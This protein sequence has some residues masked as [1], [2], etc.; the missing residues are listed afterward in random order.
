MRLRRWLRGV[1]WRANSTWLYLLCA[2]G[3][4]KLQGAREYQ[5]TIDV[6]SAIRNSGYFPGF[7]LRTPLATAA[8]KRCTAS[9]VGLPHL[10][11]FHAR[12]LD[13]EPL[14]RVAN[15]RMLVNRDGRLAINAP[16]ERWPNGAWHAGQVSKGPSEQLP[17]FPDL[18]ARDHFQ[19][20]GQ[21]RS[22]KPEFEALDQT[23]GD[24]QDLICKVPNGRSY[25]CT[26]S[27]HHG[28]MLNSAGVPSAS[29]SKPTSLT[30]A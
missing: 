16:A 19:P 11:H 5:A 17:C 14:K 1:L 12:E 29:T 25:S 20:G 6:S 2:G 18:S 23:P 4:R 27:C 22:G 15:E 3:R 24:L 30:N 28:D 9:A 26:V 7:R 10:P 8:L 21:V 13:S